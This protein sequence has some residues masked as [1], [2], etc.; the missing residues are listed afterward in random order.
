VELPEVGLDI[1]L[2]RGLLWSKR[3][4]CVKDDDGE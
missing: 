1:V 3:A 4:G 2:G